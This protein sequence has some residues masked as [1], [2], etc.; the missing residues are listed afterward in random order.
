MVMS[1]PLSNAHGNIESNE[2]AKLNC[3][4]GVIF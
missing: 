2:A 3:C 4:D 1:I